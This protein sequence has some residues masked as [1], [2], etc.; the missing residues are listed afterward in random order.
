MG[1]GLSTIAHWLSRCSS[2]LSAT[3]SE[4]CACGNR[5][6]CSL[7]SYLT[8]VIL[9]TEENVELEKAREEWEAL[10]NVQPGQMHLAVSPV[11]IKMKMTLWIFIYLFWSIS[12]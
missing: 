6:K 9:F 5:E 7:F 2:P 12:C 11:C 1:V 3:A 10:E 4:I 8:F